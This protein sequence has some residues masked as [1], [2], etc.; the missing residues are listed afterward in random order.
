MYQFIL[1]HTHVT[2]KTKINC[3][4]TYH[5][6]LSPKRYLSFRLFK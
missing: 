4:I 5:V 3:N 6:S 1:V 2:Y